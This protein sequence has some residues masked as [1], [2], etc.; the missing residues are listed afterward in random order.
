MP[1]LRFEHFCHAVC[2]I[3]NLIC[4]KRLC[5]NHQIVKGD[6]ILICIK[7]FFITLSLNS[8]GCHIINVQVVTLAC[9]H[10]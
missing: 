1:L 7:T 10:I 5:K 9:T 6:Y 4:I 3:I 8:C 2:V